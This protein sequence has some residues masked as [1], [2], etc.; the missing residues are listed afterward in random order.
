[1]PDL[2]LRLL[3]Y[4]VASAECG[5]FTAAAQRLDVTQPA[6]SQ[7][8]KRLEDL[9]GA[10]LIER[11]PRGSVQP[12]RLTL[13]GETLHEE[14]RLILA[15]AETAIRRVRSHARDNTLRVGFGTS[16]PADLT[17]A[18]IKG[19]AAVDG[20]D[21]QLVYLDWGAERVALDRGEVDAVFL[22]AQAPMDDEWVVSRPLLDL[23]RLAVFCASHQLAARA[24]ITMAD[25]DDEPI[26]DA[27]SE[28]DFW[29][30]NPRPSGRAP[31]TVGPRARTVDEMLAF[32]ATGL[33]MAITCATVAAKHSW[34]KIR[35]VP[36]SDL[37]PTTIYLL[38]R[39]NERRPL[40]RCL[41]QG[42]AT[43]NS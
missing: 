2:D 40:L 28:R 41:L 33:G 35:Y 5:T 26:I 8:V 21:L 13:A 37:A 9:I 17:D 18:V 6:L 27:A 7:G 23:P 43:G 16:T 11:A 20:A 29:I 22:Q 38:H 4:F 19:A 12:F 36:I 30:V 15:A 31:V 14:A 34:P 39:H 32:V 10:E 42:L 25:I 1:M 3:R 24:S